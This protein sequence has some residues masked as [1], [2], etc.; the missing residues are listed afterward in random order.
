[1]IYSWYTTLA[2]LSKIYK[3]IYQTS[4]R[5]IK[6]K[7]G[8]FFTMH[9]GFVKK[10]KD[11]WVQIYTTMQKIL[12]INITMKPELFV[13]GFMNVELENKYEKLLLYIVTVA[14]LL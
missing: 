10:A 5:S 7:R 3:G 14:R 9:G 8:C 11:F 1:M 2:N 12:Q 13:F 6:I 4:V